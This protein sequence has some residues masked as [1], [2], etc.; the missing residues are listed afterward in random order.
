MSVGVGQVRW[1]SRLSGMQRTITL[2]RHAAPQVRADQGPQS[3]PLSDA[4]R[5]SAAELRGR[6]P[7]PAAL[8]ASAELKAIETLCLAAS[9]TVEEIRIDD[10]FGEVVRP[11]EPFDDDYK[12]RRLAWV[13]GQLDPRHDTWETPDQVAQRFQSGLDA[14]DA[15][16]VVV[17][18]HGM[19]IT[20]WLISIG[21][22]E[23]GEAAGDLWLHLGF[24]DL[25]TATV[26]GRR[27]RC[28]VRAG[29]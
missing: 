14:L 2:I 15:D 29:R 13:T 4:G 7:S 12:A 20:A 5:R 11:G 23:P 16:A 3:W 21:H 9:V 19:A 22:V 24:P 28:R 1:V 6:L 18:G 17:A 27:D 8:A 26:V 10:R 25:I